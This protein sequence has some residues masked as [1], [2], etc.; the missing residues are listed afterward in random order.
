VKT[1]LYDDQFLAGDFVHKPV[2]VVYAPRPV[3]L[4]LMAQRLRFTDAGVG[5]AQNCIDQLVDA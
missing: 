5:V 1:A 2:F 3:A 4:P